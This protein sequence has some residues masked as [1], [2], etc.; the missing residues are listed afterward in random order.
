[1][2]IQQQAIVKAVNDLAD[3]LPAKGKMEVL[4]HL[5]STVDAKDLKGLSAE[6]RQ[7]FLSILPEVPASNA[8]QYRH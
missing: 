6:G 3:S 8:L 5:L 2:S 4:E 1:M 7:Q